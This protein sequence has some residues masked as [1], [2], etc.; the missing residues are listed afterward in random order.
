MRIIRNP[1]IKN[2][3]ETVLTVKA[4][5]NILLPFGLGLK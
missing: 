5:V 3:E 4:S 2:A 1:Q